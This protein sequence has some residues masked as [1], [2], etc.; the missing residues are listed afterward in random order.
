MMNSDKFHPTERC[1]ANAERERERILGKDPKQVSR[2][3]FV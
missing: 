3:L 1:E 2:S